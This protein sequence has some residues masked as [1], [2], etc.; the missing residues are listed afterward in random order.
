VC[1]GL[2]PLGR[3]VRRQVDLHGLHFDDDAIDMVCSIRSCSAAAAESPTELSDYSVG[4]VWGVRGDLYYL[5]DL[6]RVRLDFSG[7]QTQEASDACSGTF[8]SGPFSQM[9]SVTPRNAPKRK[10]E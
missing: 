8:S 2:R 1:G 6:V 3:A 7:T 10:R 5:L 4:T 9:P